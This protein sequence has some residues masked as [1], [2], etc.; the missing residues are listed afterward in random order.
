MAEAQPAGDSGYDASAIALLAELEPNRR[1][2]MT[3]D[4]LFLLKPD[5]EDPACPEQRFY[6]WTAF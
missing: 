6:C 1:H 4:K 2:R 5:F 3:W